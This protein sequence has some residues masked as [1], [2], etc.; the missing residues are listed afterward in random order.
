MDK[1]QIEKLAKDS[2]FISGIYNYCD[3]WCERCCFTQRCMNYALC[4][5]NDNPQSKDINNKVFWDKLGDIFKVT[6]EMVQETAE[7]LG[8][9][10]AFADLKKIE[11]YEK[12]IDRIS[13]GQ[14]YSKAAFDYSNMARD[15]FNSNKHL[16]E[17][18]ANE[19]LMLAKADIPATKPADEA[20]NI[21]DCFDII[22]WYQHQIY[23]KLCRAASG[24]LKGEFEENE[25]SPQDANGSAKVAIIGTE[26]SIGAWGKLLNHF[27][28]QEDA[29]LDILVNLKKLLQ[30]IDMAFPDA[31][32][33]TRPGFD[34][35]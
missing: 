4:D 32:S 19:L 30:Q 24:T 8:I 6:L 23:I 18:K 31:R 25:Y 34:E 14:P 22:Q 10:L 17:E 35:A 1:K 9:D 2:R 13:R 7:K 33:F 5:N 20:V 26:H 16:L 11:E 28:Q 29:I 15:W 27:P 3:R 12:D 21:R